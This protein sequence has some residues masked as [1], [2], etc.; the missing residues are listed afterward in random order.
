MCKIKM[1][2]NAK[3]PRLFRDDKT[4]F[5]EGRFDCRTGSKILM[6]PPKLEIVVDKRLK[7]RQLFRQL[8]YTA[9]DIRFKHLTC[10]RF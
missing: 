4:M 10:I 3:L 1:I 7:L 9:I 6:D 8:Y 5:D 2:F